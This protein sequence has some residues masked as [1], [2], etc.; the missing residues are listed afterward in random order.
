MIMG[1]DLGGTE[2]QCIELLNHLDED[3]YELR[4][5]ALHCQG[6]LIDKVQAKFSDIPE[7]PVSSFS[8]SSAYHQVRRLARFLKRE[9]ISILHTHDYY[10][11]LLGVM[12]AQLRGIPVIAAERDAG[13]PHYTS[14]EFGQ[15]IIYR[16]AKRILVFSE[17]GQ[18]RI[19]KNASGGSQKVVMIRNGLKVPKNFAEI[20]SKQREML[21]SDLNLKDDA[22]LL[23][24]V[25]RLQPR[26]GHLEILEATAQI[27]L[28]RPETH[29][30]FI[31]DGPLRDDIVFRIDALGVK[32]KVHLL[33][34]REDSADL[35]A[36]FDLSINAS[37]EEYLPIAVIEA[38]AMG[39]PVAAAAVPGTVELV[40][41]FDTGFLVPPGNT[42][43]LTERISYALLRRDESVMIGQRGHRCIQNGFSLGQ[44]VEA[45]EK[46]YEDVLTK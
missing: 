42:E 2:R 22:T 36:G 7:F 34:E 10:S 46:L 26:R 29:L 5:A 12:A 8:K 3:R 38:M 41:N 14:R 32:D 39:V 21:L 35:V 40:K 30:V 20:R 15:K 31:G 23:G 4:L 11:G 44:M 45:V 43:A 19:A 1:F 37:Q 25:A 27:L 18:S 33:G 13:N 24:T 9:R 28:S 6:P 17:A 16:F